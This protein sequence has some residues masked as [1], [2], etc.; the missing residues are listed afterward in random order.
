MSWARPRASSPQA[1]RARRSTRNSGK[2]CFLERRGAGFSKTKRRNNEFYW[3]NGIITPIINDTGG[4]ISLLAVQ[5]DITERMRDKER[6]EYLSERDDLTGLYNRNH[7][8][9]LIEEWI[10][11]NKSKEDAKAVLVLIN[12]DRFQAF[13]DTYGHLIGDE[14]LKTTARTLELVVHDI[15]SPELKHRSKDFIL[16]RLGGDE[17]ALFCP[18]LSVA[19]GLEVCKLVKK[20]VRG[21]S[22]GRGYNHPDGKRR[23]RILSGSR[24]DDEGTLHH[25]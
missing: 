17:F 24:R 6:I 25:G 23:G 4:I 10:F 7:F 3:V 15:D 8:M 16:S 14:Y 1:R 18:L 11:R 19:E 22:L 21:V 9:R 12:L 2:Q 13:N 5:E 20:C